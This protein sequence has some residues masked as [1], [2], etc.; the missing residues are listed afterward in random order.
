MCR[1]AFIHIVL[2]VIHGCT[3]TGETLAKPSSQPTTHRSTETPI[4]VWRA[5]AGGTIGF[6]EGQGKAARFRDP[7]GL[8]ADAAGNIY[9]ADTGNHRIRKI[10]PNGNVT[11]LA[12][13]AKG[14]RDGPAIEAQF[15]TPCGVTVRRDGAVLVA[16]TRNHRIRVITPEGMVQTLSGGNESGDRD[17]LADEARFNLPFAVAL[18]AL[19]GVVVAD[20]GNHRLRR[21]DARGTVETLA[22][23]EPGYVDGPTADARFWA[24]SDLGI[25]SLGRIY[26]VDLRNHS[27]RQFDPST[28]TVRTIAGNGRA[29]FVDGDGATAKFDLP[30]GLAVSF[31]GAIYVADGKNRAVR[32][33]APDGRVTTVYRPLASSQ[34]EEFV[35]ADVWAD[36]AGR[37]FVTDTGRS[38][39][40][41]SL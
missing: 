28:R 21:I 8:D 33:I 34:S 23:K 30:T 24:P 19:D 5:I 41:S 6:A 36:S 31:G 13:G 12:G 29:G 2:I 4:S 40:I 39:V 25:D 17:G 26:V 10:S 9:V 32:L 14:F 15:D 22:G 16:D 18:D 7:N 3:G 27:I 38:Q 1:I 20:T 37:L 11:N 35:P